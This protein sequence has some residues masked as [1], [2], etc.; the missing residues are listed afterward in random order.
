[1]DDN[2]QLQEV[3]QQIQE[4]SRK[5]TRYARLQ[6]LFSLVAV[7]CCAALLVV[8]IDMIPQVEQALEEVDIL[9]AQAKTLAGQAQ[10]VL[11]NL[12]TVTEE[13]AEAD[14]STMV[15]NMDDLVLTSQEGVSKALEKMEA[16]DIEALN[17]AVANLAAVVEPMAKFFKVFQ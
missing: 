5:Q 8:A 3:L 11:G 9:A 15:Q 4:N 7:L 14:F 17:K 12:E 2:R 16:M 13:L 6:C 1:M 10:T